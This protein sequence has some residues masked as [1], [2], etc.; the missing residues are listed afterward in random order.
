M[1]KNNLLASGIIIGF[2]IFATYFGA[3]NLIFPPQ[4]GLSSGNQ[5]VLGAIGTSITAIILPIIAVVG[6]LNAGG[7]PENLVKPVAPW[8]YK[9]FYFIV[10]VF[11]GAGSTLPRSA[12]TTYEMGIL[13][14]TN[15]L[16]IWLVSGVFFV[17]FY[18]FANNKDNVIEKI[19]KFL[20]PV[21]LV[22]L[23][24]IIG[25][26]IISPIGTPVDTGITNPLASSMIS[27]YLTGDLTLGVL[28]SGMFIT[29]FY[30]Q[31]YNKKQVYNGT[32]IA[33]FIAF[34]GL[35]IIY[36]GLLYG[37]A[38]LSGELPQN[39][40]RTTLLVTI[41]SR[42]LGQPGLLALSISVTLACLTT[43]V[44][45]GATLGVFLEDISNKKIKYKTWI[46]IEAILC[47][48]LSI[49]GV[50]GLINYVTPLFLIIYP[51]CIVLTFLGIFDKF[52]PNDGLYKAGVFMSFL[53]GCVDA[54]I[55]VTGSQFLVNLITK[56]P[57]GNLGFAWLL[58]TVVAMILGYFAFKDV[59]RVAKLNEDITENI[60]AGMDIESV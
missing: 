10:L 34:L 22:L 56:I 4:I 36:T 52:V 30:S 24:L 16:P 43:S 6:V 27:G 20:T 5:W 58:P 51:M 11:I 55:E 23:F 48:A 32:L 31:G 14:I 49:Q 25:K 35:F 2:A 29:A 8:F 47:F 12:A 38:C 13:P 39:I 45:V 28:C 53:F 46:F 60:N 19:G 40:E 21:L 59:P 37:G 3:G 18:L 41:V 54:A 17:L 33:C 9:V 7:S 44:G 50:T 57:L 26:A 15:S 1:K 42:V